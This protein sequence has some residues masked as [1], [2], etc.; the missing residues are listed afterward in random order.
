MNTSPTGRLPL[1]IKKDFL[2]KRTHWESTHGRRPIFRRN[3]LPPRSLPT[4]RKFCGWGVRGRALF[5][6]SA[7]PRTP[8]PQNFRLVGRLRGGSSF[9]R[10]MGR[11][12]WVLSQ[13]VL[14]CKKSFFIRRG[15]LPVGLVFNVFFLLCLSV[16]GKFQCPPRPRTGIR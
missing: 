4:S 5:I 2:Q 10:K 14:F 8:H 13:C 6:K 1:R 15:S 7:L 16:E 3:E 11:L 9:R 12:P